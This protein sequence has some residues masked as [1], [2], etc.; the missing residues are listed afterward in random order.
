[1]DILR[2][3]SSNM[4][5]SDEAYEYLSEIASGSKCAHFSGADLQAVRI[6]ASLVCAS[7]HW[8]SHCFFSCVAS[9]CTRRS[10]NSCTKSSMAIV[11]STCRSCLT[12]RLHC[13]TRLFLAL[14][15]SV[16]VC[17]VPLSL[18]TAVSSPRRTFKQ[19][20]TVRTH[21]RP[22][23]LDCTLSD[24]TAVSRELA[25]RTFPSHKPMSQQRLS[26]SSRTSLTNAQLSL[27]K[28]FRRSIY[29]SLLSQFDLVEPLFPIVDLSCCTIQ[30]KSV[31]SRRK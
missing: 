30:R 6:A 22:K 14:F 26:R 8:H 5:L 2:A 1:M 11:P 13:I 28:T 31:G 17:I 10:S 4:D 27:S 23:L 16:P 15:W 25:R 12:P 3:V 7:A 20:L 19:H 18:V 24:C 29:R 21:R 9:S